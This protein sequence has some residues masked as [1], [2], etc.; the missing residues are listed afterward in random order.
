MEEI[1]EKLY[2]NKIELKVINPDAIRNVD[3][4]DK[5]SFNKFIVIINKKK[6]KSIVKL[7]WKGLI[8]NQICLG[9]ELVGNNF[10][11]LCYNR[12]FS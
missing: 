3:S 10:D 7:L 8:D 1:K 9:C 6:K 12:N 11:I 2:C 4:K 5:T